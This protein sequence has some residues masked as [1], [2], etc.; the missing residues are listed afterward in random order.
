MIVHLVKEEILVRILF[1]TLLILV[2]T[3]CSRM[4]PNLTPTLTWDKLKPSSILEKPEG[5]GPFPAIILLHGGS[6]IQEFHYTWAKRLKKSGYVTLMLDSLSPRNAGNTLDGFT[7]HPAK[8]AL[9]AHAGKSYLS[10]LSYVDCNKIA[11][12]GWSHGG[13]SV[14][15]ALR[16]QWTTNPKEPFKAAV[17]L[18][19]YCGYSNKKF[20]DLNAPLLILAGGQDN[21]TPSGECLERIPSNELSHDLILKVY[22][23][24][25]HNFDNIQRYREAMYQG[26]IVK[27]DAVATKK[28]IN[29]VN[30]F[31][32]KH[33][34]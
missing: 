20:N 14:L 1:S 25:Y 24:A 18:Y 21:W 31:L 12:M 26:K 7:V 2:I 30:L 11:V 23:N 19:P 8:R 5:S 13:W 4:D 28:A 27:Y 22:P 32:K 15:Y 34:K 6:G 33:L 17:A 16:D 9:D 29:D 10:K 3:S